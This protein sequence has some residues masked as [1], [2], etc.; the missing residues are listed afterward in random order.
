MFLKIMN[1]VNSGEQKISLLL[2]A[3]VKKSQ[4]LIDIVYRVYITES[5]S[6]SSLKKLFSIHTGNVNV[7]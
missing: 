4:S 7:N 2:E 3:A 6:F 1:K 5:M